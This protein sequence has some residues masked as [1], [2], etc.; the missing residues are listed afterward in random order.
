M[1]P[2]FHPQHSTETY[3]AAHRLAMRRP[4]LNAL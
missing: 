1:K 3:L 2:P 4:K